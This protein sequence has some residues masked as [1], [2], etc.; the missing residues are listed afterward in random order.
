MRV[1]SNA[2]G[3]IVL[4]VIFGGIAA[5][6][7]F[8]MWNTSSEKIPA[9]YQTGEFEGQFDPSD[10]RGSYTFGDINNVFA[11][12]ADTL[13]MAFG[14]SNIDD[15]DSFQVKNLESLYAGLK[16]QGKE[17]GAGSVRVFT[18]LYLGLPVN[19]DEEYFLPKPAAD[20]LVEKGNL[21]QE[22]L[23]YVNIHVVDMD[24]IPGEQGS[25]IE[26]PPADEN[27]QDERVVKG[28]TTFHEL[29]SWGVSEQQVEEIIGGKIP[30]PGMTVREYCQNN[31]ISFSSIK[32]ILNSL[33]KK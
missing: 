30:A 7:L 12:P 33:I 11:V 9:R 8:N 28:T 22:Q 20:I 16:E 31:G 1:K 21:T 27:T 32:E 14:V 26:K 4:V 29:I 5:S 24:N 2:L 15:I 18:G 3:L 23:G 19:L 10:I 13:A 17:I 6:S 25:L